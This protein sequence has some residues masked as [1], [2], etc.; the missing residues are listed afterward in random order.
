MVV[1]ALE[2]EGVEDVRAFARELNGKLLQPDVFAHP[3]KGAAH[4]YPGVDDALLIVV[5]E[6]LYPPIWIGSLLGF[7][8]SFLFSWYFLI[9]T[10]PLALTALLWTRPFYRWLLVKGL[11]KRAGVGLRVRNVRMADAVKRVLDGAD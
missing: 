1:F 11:K 7:A 8:A 2:T 5:I 4:L 9:P 10:L 6:P 3:F